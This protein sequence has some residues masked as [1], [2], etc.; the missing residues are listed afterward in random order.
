MFDLPKAPGAQP[1]TG[2][3]KALSLP[4][5]ASNHCAH[6]LP[7][8]ASRV[9]LLAQYRIAAVLSNPITLPVSSAREARSLV[10]N[11]SEARMLVG[12][13]INAPLF[14]LAD[15]KASCFKR[16]L[17]FTESWMSSY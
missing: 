1:L 16:A 11:E 6:L 13:D 12:L 9:P 7:R 15:C 4:K 10:S 2:Y 14:V 3:A 8:I 5:L 17:R